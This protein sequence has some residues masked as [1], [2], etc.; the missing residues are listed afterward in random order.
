M[1]KE[2]IIVKLSTREC[3]TVQSKLLGKE[4]QDFL[5][6]HCFHYDPGTRATAVQL[7]KHTFVKVRTCTR[8]NDVLFCFQTSTDT[9]CRTMSLT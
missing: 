8:M 1:S 9:P 6:T 2:D 7:L 4:G 5:Q 3:P